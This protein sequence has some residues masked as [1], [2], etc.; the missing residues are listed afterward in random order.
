[1]AQF[2]KHTMAGGLAALLALEVVLQCLPVSSATMTGYH[3]DPKILTYPPHHRWTVSTGWDLKNAQSLSS[4][5]Y[6]FASQRDFVPGSQAVALIGDSYVEASMLEAA[7]RPAAQLEQLL[8]G[9]PVYAMGGPGSS[10]LDYAERIR[11]ARQQLG[12]K[13]IVVLLERTDALQAICG[14]GN[15]HSEC[16]DR[17]A[18]AFVSAPQ[19]GAGLLKSVLRHSAL[20]QY[21]M[22]QL[23]LSPQAL[24]STAFWS[25][26]QLAVTGR[27]GSR[28]EISRDPHDAEAEWVDRVIAEF[29]R[30]IGT[31]TDSRLVFV[32]DMNRG[33]LAEHRPSGP[34]GNEYLVRRLREH[35][36]RVIDAAPIFREHATASRL[37]LAVGPYDGHLNA[38]GVRLLMQ[39]VANVVG[40]APDRQG[41]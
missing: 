41:G 6:G 19:P 14:S 34:D 3:M 22:G 1:M 8:G 23:K 27:S 28:G 17:H 32:V 30:R 4:N 37:Q 12:L 31:D 9:R 25:P 10:L 33:L 26:G 11:W 2:L 13:D 16:L 18:G 7:Q 15:V 36:L 21:L 35:G 24:V 29:C 38:L 39:Q 20:A 40:A 5:N